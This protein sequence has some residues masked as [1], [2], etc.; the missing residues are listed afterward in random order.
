MQGDA[1]MTRK[2]LTYKDLLQR[3]RKKLFVGREEEREAFR[4]NFGCEVPEHL[5]FAIHGQAGIGKSFLVARY[6]AIAR[7][8]GALTALTNEAEAMAIREQSILR[9]MARLAKQLAEAD[10][11]LKDFNE[12]YQ[13]YRECMQQVETDPKAPQGV[14][15]LLGR[16]TARLAIGG[17]RMTP[18][19]QAVGGFLKDVG[20]DD[21][22][23]VEQAGAWTA[24]L[25]K[26][27]KNRDEVALV[28]EPVETLTPLFVAGVNEQADEQPV[29]LCF[30]TWERTGAH[31]DEWLRGLLKREGLSAG[32]WLVVAG[33]NPPG[34]EWE[35]FHPLMAS[36]E[37][38]EFTEEETRGYLKQQGITEEA[39]VA[40]ILAFSGGVPVLV[41]TLASAK[42]GSATEA[43][44]DLVDRYLKWV[45]DRGQRET[46]LNCAAA[47]RLDKDV[48]AAVMGG[49][50]A[51]ELFD[52][53]TGMP[54]VQSRP[55]YW[56]YHP[57]V[58][59]LMLKYARSRSVRDSQTVHN[60]LEA[61]YRSLLAGE[62]EG[63]YRDEMSQRHMLEVLYHGLMQESAGAKCAGPELFLLVLRIYYPLAGE[64]AMTWQQ[65]AEEREATNEIT[66]WARVLGAG[67]AAIESQSLKSVLLFCEAMRER[68][69]LSDAAR[70]E[71]HLLGGVVYSQLQDYSRAIEEYGLAIGLSP[72]DALVY[73]GRGSVY[74]ALQDYEQAIEDYGQA[75]DLNPEYAE[76]YYNRG[77]AYHT[78]Q[79]Y[80]R[81]AE[82]YGRAIDLNPEYAE[83][84]Y[85]RGVAYQDL[86]NYERAVEDFGRAADLDPEYT[87][88]HYNLGLA[89]HQ[90][91]NYERAI[92]EYGRAIE[93]N[94]EYTA[95]YLNRGLAYA[96][97]QDYERAIEDFG[98][99]IEL[100]PED[101]AAYYNRASVYAE[102]QDYERIVEDFERVIELNPKDAGA[103]CIR[104]LA[105]AELQDYARA[106]KDYERAI[107]L[108]PE[109]AI[110]YYNTACAYT[111]MGEA[112]EAC[113]WLAKAIGLDEKC[114]QMAREAP[115]FDGIREDGRFKALVGE[116]G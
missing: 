28:K 62:E 16:T 49:D 55:G 22:A 17:A 94:P 96:E 7:E 70:S 8:N 58:R 113:E 57:K 102:L 35:P 116:N 60:N 95:A 45:D 104:G 26:K 106:I 101:A 5:I 56:E 30:D 27:F 112:G 75:I 59:K 37:L 114:L 20:V 64:I 40:D 36:F 67:W 100:N 12:R 52:W 24:Y 65:V 32:V 99:A 68:K 48:V 110:A 82:D 34:D 41:S 3:R 63:L 54:F 2:R 85:N 21:E 61:Y 13:K 87:E 15:D 77:V 89:Y 47:R 69:D 74:Y 6:Q 91:Q 90:L 25:A 4:R 18:V 109:D 53:L 88:T 46:A 93:L 10:A 115:D 84:Y 66:R 111:L 23:L 83:A 76:A 103:Y 31:L 43:A 86:Q 29:V 19:G 98:R 14:F 71:V 39:R 11:P 80:E 108:N 50:D 9:A 38:K 1:E 97:L 51:S 81:A 42:G 79:N 105:Y 78:L 73:K 33:R 107:E 92:E 44:N 72:K